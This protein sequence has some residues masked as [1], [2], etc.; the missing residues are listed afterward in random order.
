MIPYLCRVISRSL[1]VDIELRVFNF[2]SISQMIFRSAANDFSISWERFSDILTSVLWALP[3]WKLY[4]EK[5]WVSVECSPPRPTSYKLFFSRKGSL[6]S[7][8][9]CTNVLR[10]TFYRTILHRDFTGKRTVRMKLFLTN[11]QLYW[12]SICYGEGLDKG[13]FMSYICR[14]KT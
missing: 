10:W 1:G 6:P 2:C 11:L 7:D 3:Y 5:A 9:F 13:F 4:Q 8:L 14:W 12:F